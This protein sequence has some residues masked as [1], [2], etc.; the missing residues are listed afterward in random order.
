MTFAYSRSLEITL[1]CNDN[2]EILS[3]VLLQEKFLTFNNMIL[4]LNGRSGVASLVKVTPISLF[5][6]SF[7]TIFERESSPV[8][9][10]LSFC[11]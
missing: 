7:S 5:C 11:T 9:K 6:I 3:Q 1:F 10:K 8:I 4:M 2:L